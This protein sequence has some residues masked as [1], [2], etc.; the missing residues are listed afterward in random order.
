ME[1]PRS[2]IPR[3]RHWTKRNSDGP[4]QGGRSAKLTNP[5]FI[6]RSPVIPRIRQLLQA[7]HQRLLPGSSTTHQADKE[8]PGKMGLEPGS[9]NGVQEIKRTIHYG[10]HPDT[11]QRVPTS[12]P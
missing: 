4:R 8:N 9:R 6:N 12:H 10:T 5:E 11:F 2:G 7:L 3:L 1:G